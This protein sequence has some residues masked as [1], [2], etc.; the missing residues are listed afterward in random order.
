MSLQNM[1]QTSG[2][3]AE[4]N[5]KHLEEE[6]TRKKRTHPDTTDITTPRPHKRSRKEPIHNAQMRS[7]A[8]AATIRPADIDDAEVP[9]EQTLLESI[10]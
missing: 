9:D 5:T 7:L 2:T 8:D 10:D 1:A 3:L 6:L 4:F